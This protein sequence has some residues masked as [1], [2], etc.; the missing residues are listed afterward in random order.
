MLGCGGED[1]SIVTLLYASGTVSVSLLG[2]FLSVGSSSK[3]SH[4]SLPISLL[5]CRV[6]DYFSKKRGRQQNFIKPQ[7]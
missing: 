3:S 2:S 5:A 4:P 7:Q 1:V 6:E